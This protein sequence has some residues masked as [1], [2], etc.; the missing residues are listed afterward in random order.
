MEPLHI[1][2]DIF[3]EM[4]TSINTS[5]REEAILQIKHGRSYTTTI[6]GIAYSIGITENNEL[7]IIP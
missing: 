1:D 4:N 6:D 2:Y 3:K 5:L 7:V